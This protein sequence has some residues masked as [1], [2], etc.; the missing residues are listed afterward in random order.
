MLDEHETHTIFIGD[1][2]AEECLNTAYTHHAT[3]D[4]I[5]AKQNGQTPSSEQ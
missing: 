5:A 3:S 4:A 2:D 1:N